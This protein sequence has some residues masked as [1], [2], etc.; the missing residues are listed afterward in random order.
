VF[1]RAY[2]KNADKFKQITWDF[3]RAGE[4]TSTTY[5]IE[6]ANVPLIKKFGETKDE[7]E[8]LKKYKQFTW[9]GFFAKPPVSEIRRIMSINGLITE[10]VGEED[11]DGVDF[12]NDSEDNEDVKF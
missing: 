11:D 7:K 3:Y 6:K 10:D 1:E 4:G 12:D 9:E 8:I 5:H 2:K